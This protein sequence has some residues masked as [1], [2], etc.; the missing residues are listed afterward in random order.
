MR[1]IVVLNCRSLPSIADAG[2]IFVVCD[3]TPSTRQ[4]NISST[5]SVIMY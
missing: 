1:V 5:T 4:V 3:V 2:V